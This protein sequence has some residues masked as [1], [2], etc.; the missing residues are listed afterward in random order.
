MRLAARAPLHH[1]T[2]A[3]NV[4][5]DVTGTRFL[6]LYR[7]AVNDV[8]SL[9]AC[10]RSSGVSVRPRCQGAPLRSTFAFLRKQIGIHA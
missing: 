10:S 7:P 9:I 1:H 3:D 5:I 6:T 4:Y 2:K 8:M